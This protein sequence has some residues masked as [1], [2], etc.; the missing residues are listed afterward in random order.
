MLSGEHLAHLQGHQRRELL[1]AGGD[2]LE[3]RAQ[4][5]AALARRGGRP[6][7]LHGG[8][9]VEG[10]DAVLGGGVGDGD[11]HLVGRRG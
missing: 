10:G 2:R 11:Q 7:L 1:G 8:G 5:L 4:D 6:F 3:H 9:R